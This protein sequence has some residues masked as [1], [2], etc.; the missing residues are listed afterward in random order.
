MAPWIQIRIGLA[1][2]IR[3]LI[4]IETDADPQH[5]Y[6]V[7]NSSLFFIY[8]I[9]LHQ[10]RVFG[11]AVTL[12]RGGGRGPEQLHVLLQ[13]RHRLHGP[14]TLQARPRRPRQDPRAE[15]R[16]SQGIPLLG[17]VQLSILVLPL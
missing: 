11:R 8:I 13:A 1:P 4:R 14:L 3:I 12:P 10:G 7:L 9:S 16:L 17:G 5:W 15:A 6:T 2:W